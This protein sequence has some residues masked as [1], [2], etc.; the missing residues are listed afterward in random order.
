MKFMKKSK[1]EI[2][3]IHVKYKIYYRRKKMFIIVRVSQIVL[4][5]VQEAIQL[6][7]YPDELRLGKFLK[8]SMSFTSHQL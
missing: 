5:T 3:H 6:L 2:L 8:M 4:F 7:S 1:T